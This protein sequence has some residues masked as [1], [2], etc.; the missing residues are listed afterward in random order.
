MER[1]SHCCNVE[2][3]EL[4]HIVGRTIGKNALQP[5]RTSY[6]DANAKKE[7]TSS[8]WHEYPEP[9][10]FI[11]DGRYMCYCAQVQNGPSP[12]GITL[13]SRLFELHYDGFE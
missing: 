12:K 13:V 2:S 10:H 9:R 5:R 4:A 1:H 8:Q 6:G 11:R 3:I 7:R